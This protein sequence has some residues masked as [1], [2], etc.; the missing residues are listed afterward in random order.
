MQQHEQDITAKAAQAKSKAVALAVVYAHCVAN[1][2]QTQKRH[3]KTTAQATARTAAKPLA[4]I[5]N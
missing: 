4:E 5:N 3:K 1:D 2:L